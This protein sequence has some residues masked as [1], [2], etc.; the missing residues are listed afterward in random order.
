M[1]FLKRV[2]QLNIFNSAGS[3]V[4]WGPERVPKSFSEFPVFQRIKPRIDGRTGER[5]QFHPK[6]RP[7]DIFLQAR[8]RRET[9]NERRNQTGQPRND[10]NTDNQADCVGGFAVPLRLGD[11]FD[12]CVGGD[13]ARLFL[14]GLG[15]VVVTEGDDRERE[16]ERDKRQCQP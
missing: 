15:E 14:G 11:L 8:T 5:Q 16:G 7:S 13:L 12:V 2:L 10:E 3:D 1:D 4:L 9:M 6:P